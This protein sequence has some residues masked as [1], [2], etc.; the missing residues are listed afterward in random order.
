MI[1]YN[2]RHDFNNRQYG[3]C[4]SLFSAGSFLKDKVYLYKI[5][6]QIKGLNIADNAKIK[7]LDVGCSHGSFARFLKD[8]GFDVYGID[9]SRRAA[10]KALEFGIKAIQ[11]D[12][13]QRIDFFDNYFDIVIA[14]EIIEHLYDTDYFLQEI[15]RVAKDNG[16]LFLSTPNLASLKNRIRLL[17]GKYPRHS[18]YRLGPGLSGHIRNYTVSALKLQIKE[19]NWRIIKITSPNFLCP[20]TKN[21]PIFIKKIAMFLGDI[22]YTLGSHIIITAKKI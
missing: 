12:V 7:I 5:F 22:F 19:N 18:E 11:C 10:A 1:N 2:K 14:A 3:G 16:Y 9:I 15:T 21:I 6:I 17:A 8:Q 20:M 13:E 4:Q